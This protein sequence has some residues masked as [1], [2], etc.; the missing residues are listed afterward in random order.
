MIDH[1]LVFLGGA[2]AC[3]I[4]VALRMRV[5]GESAFDTIVRPLGAGG[6]GPRK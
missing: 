5:P 6:P 3:F 2:A 1:I 4:G